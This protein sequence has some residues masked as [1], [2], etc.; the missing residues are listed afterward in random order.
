VRSK[1]K[2]RLF[3]IAS[4][5]AIAL[6]ATA[7]VIS[8][9]AK[10]KSHDVDATALVATVKP[11]SAPGKTTIGAGYATGDPYGKAAVILKTK[12]TNNPDG[13]ATLDS[14]VTLYNRRGSV[15]GTAEATVTPKPDGSATFDGKGEITSGTGRFKGARGDFEVTGS[16]P[17]NSSISTLNVTGS[18][19][20]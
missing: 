7:A 3:V 14:K 17:A 11:A 5:A 18:V 13:T 8:Q 4:V 10:R 9:A 19:K 12:A 16:Q 2:I 1:R 20:Y 15:S 6:V